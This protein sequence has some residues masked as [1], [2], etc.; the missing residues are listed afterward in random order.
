MGLGIGSVVASALSLLSDGCLCL[1]VISYV[2]FA[3]TIILSI[4]GVALG[5]PTWILGSRDLASM[6]AGKM[7]PAGQGMTKGGWICGIIGTFLGVLDM[8]CITGL[9]IVGIVA[10]VALVI[11]EPPL[12]RREGFMPTQISCPSCARPLRV[13][14]DLLGQSVRCPNCQTTFTAAAPAEASPEPAPSL[15]EGAVG[16]QTEPA[17][18]KPQRDKEDDYDYSRPVATTS[19]SEERSKVVHTGASWSWCWVSSVW[20]SRCLGCVPT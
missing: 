6:R 20:P 4:L 1:P 17:E 9:C 14:E 3:A 18:Q 2:A 15:G 5:I 10:G 8:L 19:P 11:I 13:S 7:D 16:V 12:S